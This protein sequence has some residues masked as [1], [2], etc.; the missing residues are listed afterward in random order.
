MR[1]RCDRSKGYTRNTPVGGGTKL[2]SAVPYTECDGP[3]M[4][5]HGQ[6]VR[7]RGPDLIG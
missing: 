6:F 1:G 5:P 7:G 4:K 2:C 3:G